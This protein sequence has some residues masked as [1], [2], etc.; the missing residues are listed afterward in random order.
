LALPAFANAMAVACFTAF[1]F[2]AGLLV[3]I[4]PGLEYDPHHLT[5]MFAAHYLIT[6]TAF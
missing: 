2:D 6:L 3:P 4:L 5:E 1:C